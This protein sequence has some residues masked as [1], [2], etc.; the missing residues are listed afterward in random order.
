VRH[1]GDREKCLEAGLDS[2]ISKPIQIAAL[3]DAASPIRQTLRLNRGAA[4][5]PACPAGEALF[6]GQA[7]QAA[8][9]LYTQVMPGLLY[10]VG[11]AIGNL[12]DITY[13]AVRALKEADLIAC[14]DTP[15]RPAS[16]STLRHRQA[17]HQLPRP[18]RGR[19]QRR[20]G[21]AAAR[22]AVVALVSDAGT[23]WCRT[24]ATGW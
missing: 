1:E 21:G 4:G 23:R 24:R 8:A 13:R 16:C 15:A 5:L 12:E 2:Y 14:E 9:P 7:G 18:Q 10:L 6:S 3:D 17:G 20:A 19:T 11:H 22:G